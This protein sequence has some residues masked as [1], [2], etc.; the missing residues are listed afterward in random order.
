MVDFK[1]MSL[2]HLKILKLG[3]HHLQTPFPLVL[4]PILHGYNEV[5]KSQHSPYASVPM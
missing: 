4:K 2:A 5:T 1:K 3:F